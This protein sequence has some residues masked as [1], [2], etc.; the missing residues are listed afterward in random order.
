MPASVDRQNVP[1]LTVDANKVM[2][3]TANSDTQ[4][5]GKA[6]CF[7]FLVDGKL[8]EGYNYFTVILFGR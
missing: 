1:R 7:P 3:A 2:Q 6:G 8:Q 4:T 5:K